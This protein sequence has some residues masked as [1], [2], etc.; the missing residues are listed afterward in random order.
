MY[1]VILLKSSIFFY[2]LYDYVTMTVT[3]VRLL[4]YVYVTVVTVILNCNL[5]F[6]NRKIKIK[7]TIFNSNATKNI[8][9]FGKWYHLF[10]V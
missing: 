5:R 10:N 9:L 6:Q 8:A 1:N 4:Q 7:S 2:I 3:Y